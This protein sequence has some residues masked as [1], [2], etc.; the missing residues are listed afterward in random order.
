MLELRPGAPVTRSPLAALSLASVLVAQAPAEH[1]VA[2]RDRAL[3]LALQRKESPTHPSRG[4]QTLSSS[5][6]LVVL[7]HRSWPTHRAWRL[8]GRGARISGNVGAR[9]IGTGN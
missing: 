3:N 4:G 1:P 7:P 9:I 5:F 8:S 2:A 6:L